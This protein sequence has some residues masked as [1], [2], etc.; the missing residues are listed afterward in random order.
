MKNLIVILVFVSS[1]L[2][3]E[4]LGQ[5]VYSDS[6]GNLKVIDE[7]REASIRTLQDEINMLV[8]RRDDPKTDIGNRLS[9]QA[10]IDDL[11]QQRE[12]IFS[13]IVGPDIEVV[14]KKEYDALQAEVIILK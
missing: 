8:E 13:G 6:N 14:P 1:F 11:A 2:V 5:K 7:V 10:E 9:L 4:S 3:T 12:A